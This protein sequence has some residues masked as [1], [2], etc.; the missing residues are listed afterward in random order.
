MWEVLISLVS[1]SLGVS[2]ITTFANEKFEKQIKALGS[3]IIVTAII[4]YIMGLEFDIE[5]LFLKD[6]L[7]TD[8]I[9]I[10]EYNVDTVVSNVLHERLYE[11]FDSDILDVVTDGI[12]ND[13]E[14][15]IDCVRI[16]VTRNA[17]GSDVLNFV[18][19]ELKVQGKIVVVKSDGG[20]VE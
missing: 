11:R 16:T 19:D 5:N 15:V 7:V 3:I 20:T 17:S 1:V 4:S 2:V 14:Y 13:E 18:K 12:L 10:T 6:S 9:S 8:T